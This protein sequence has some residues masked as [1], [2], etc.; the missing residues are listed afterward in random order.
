MGDIII[1][2]VRLPASIR[3]YTLT[4]DNDDY[5]VYVN[6]ALNSIQRQR[7]IDHEIRHIKGDHFFRDSDVATDEKEAS[8]GQNRAVAGL[9]GGNNSVKV[10]PV[11]IKPKPRKDFKNLRTD[12]GLTQYQAAKLAGIRPSVYAQYEQGLFPCPPQEE[13]KILEALQKK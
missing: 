10:T 1:R 4:D 11:E 8:M 12:R 5:N 13:A 2:Y 3:A 7:A 9:Y 6:S